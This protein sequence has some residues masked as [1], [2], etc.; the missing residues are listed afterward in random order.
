[1]V[2]DVNPG[3]GNGDPS[4]ITAIGNTLYFEATS[5][6]NGS[7]LWKVE[8]VSDGSG[9]LATTHEITLS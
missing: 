1:M 8:M 3:T 2:Q 6:N 4:Y 5:S 9:N 7:E